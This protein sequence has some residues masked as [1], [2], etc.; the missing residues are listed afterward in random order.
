MAIKH[1]LELSTAHVTKDTMA[2]IEKEAALYAEYKPV[3]FWAV[4]FI[5]GAFIC[6][7]YESDNFDARDIPSDLRQVIL[8]AKVQG[9]E[10]IY[11]DA[12]EE[13]IDDLPV[14]KWD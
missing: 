8:Y 9:C 2:R 7:A 10:W 12:D 13:T 3:S 6:T 1:I 14:Y 11:F 4:K 5:Y